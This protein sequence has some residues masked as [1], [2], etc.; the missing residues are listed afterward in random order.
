MPA[1]QNYGI[2][3]IYPN[4]S[5]SRTLTLAGDE[6]HRAV[7]V[8]INNNTVN[9]LAN[10][11]I[12]LNLNGKTLSCTNLNVYCYRVL[13]LS[14]SAT[15]TPLNFTNCKAILSG[16][17]GGIV[18]VSDSV[19][20]YLRQRYFGDA[21]TDDDTVNAGASTFDSNTEARI[22]AGSASFNITGSVKVYLLLDSSST[23]GSDMT[24]TQGIIAGNAVIDGGTSTWTVGG[25]VYTY[26]SMDYSTTG[27]STSAT[28]SGGSITG[29]AYID[30]GNSTWNVAVMSILM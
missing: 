7:E 23:N 4:N 27:A 12:T 18:N 13:N 29:K 22:N 1:Y 21:E 14:G 2:F 24:V 15:Y 17:S 25:S 5:S 3:Y 6:K 19:S 8:Y 16:A 10:T 28:I 30:A 20:I 26:A 11:S 9:A